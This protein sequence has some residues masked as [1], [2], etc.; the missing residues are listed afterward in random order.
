MTPYRILKQTR[1]N[2]SIEFKIQAN[3]SRHSDTE[4]WMTIET[5]SN[6]KDA[7]SS[8][9]RRRGNEII[10]EEVIEA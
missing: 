6:L 9:E 10:K 8:V 4:M 3:R 5:C 2:G 7:Q 1:A